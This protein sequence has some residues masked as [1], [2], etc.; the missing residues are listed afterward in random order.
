MIRHA[1]PMEDAR[2]VLGILLMVLDFFSKTIEVFLRREFGERYFNIGFIFLAFLVINTVGRFADNFHSIPLFYYSY[3]FVLMSAWHELRIFQR[4]R[5][6]IK[7]HSYHRGLSHLSLLGLPVGL[8]QRFLEPGLVIVGG[9]IVAKQDGIFGFYLLLAGFGL[10]IGEQIRYKQSKKIVLDAIDSQIEA[11]NLMAA[12]VDER[13]ST[14]T[15]GVSFVGLPKQ[16]R[17]ESEQ[18]AETIKRMDPQMQA[19]LSR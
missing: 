2:A 1:D 6:G 5:Q 10:L 15:Q 14:Q 16:T 13:P 19:L 3:A 8:V 4:N 9:F 11:E 12:L 17:E 7:W 18:L